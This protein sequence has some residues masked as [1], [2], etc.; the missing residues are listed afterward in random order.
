MSDLDKR[1]D[2][3]E[4][5]KLLTHYS[6]ILLQ[7][8]IVVIVQGLV[9]LGGIGH[10]TLKGEYFYSFLASLFGFFL[11]L[12]LYVLH[13]NYYRHFEIIG[14][15]TYK[16]Y[17]NIG[18]DKG[19]ETPSVWTVYWRKRMSLPRASQKKGFCCR[20]F[21]RYLKHH[22]TFLLF[23]LVYALLALRNWILY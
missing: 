4:A 18:K 19:G 14:A 2:Y 21:A 12:T 9:V 3:I 5:L 10:L 1:T 11:S 17:E 22:S 13:V 15:H 16:F 8:R 23:L 7:L 20:S 6:N